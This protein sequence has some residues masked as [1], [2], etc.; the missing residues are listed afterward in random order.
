VFNF[1]KIRYRKGST[2]IIERDTAFDTYCDV[3]LESWNLRICWVELREARSRGNT[4]DTV[5][6]GFDRAFGDISMVTMF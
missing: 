3:R 5:T 6:L 1:D 2:L 4:K